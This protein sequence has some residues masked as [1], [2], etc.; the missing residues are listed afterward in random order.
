MNDHRNLHNCPIQA[1]PTVETEA[2]Q[3]TINEYVVIT[4]QEHINIRCSGQTP[5][6]HKI[7]PGTLHL[8]FNSL[9]CEVEGGEGWILRG[10]QVSQST[11]EYKPALTNTSLLIFPNFPKFDRLDQVTLEKL[12]SVAGISMKQMVGLSQ[13]RLPIYHEHHRW[14]NTATIVT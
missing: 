4:D 8:I 14:G 5:I 11:V 9:P 12:H 3:V 13:T 10:K 2:E 7:T 1:L 6:K